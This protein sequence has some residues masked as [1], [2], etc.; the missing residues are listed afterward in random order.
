LILCG[1]RYS[2]IGSTSVDRLLFGAG[3]FAPRNDEDDDE[4]EAAGFAI[5]DDEDE[6]DDAAE[7]DEDEDEATFGTT[8]ASLALEAI[9]ISASSPSKLFL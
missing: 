2:W 6:D 3:D 5:E 9:V 4:E 7:D 1:G 8:S